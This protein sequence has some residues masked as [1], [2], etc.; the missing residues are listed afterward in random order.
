MP[1]LLTRNI[2]I[3]IERDDQFN[4]DLLPNVKSNFGLALSYGNY[5]LSYSVRLAN[6]QQD[7]TIYGG[8]KYKDLSFSYYSS[9]FGGEVYYSAYKGFYTD[10]KKL[11]QIRIFPNLKTR[12]MG[13]NLFYAANR[14]YSLKAAF[15]AGEQQLR[16]RGS[17]IVATSYRY[18]RLSNLNEILT[19]NGLPTIESGKF[20]S[21]SL[22]LG[23]GYTFVKRKFYLATGALIGPGLEFQ[24]INDKDKTENTQNISFR[25]LAKSALGYNGNR[26][27]CFFGFSVDAET[28]YLSTFDLSQNAYEMSLNIGY[29][30]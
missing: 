13:F 29:R 12:T 17:I 7:P 20:R 5:G 23:Y 24:Q 21:I 2:R 25:M 28:I 27:L 16:S 8:T 19:P 6:S 14:K 3:S 30:F 18:T 9:R 4:I 10:E 11:D 1:Y 22:T 15:K 26:F